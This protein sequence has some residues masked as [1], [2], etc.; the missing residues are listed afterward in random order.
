MNF[1]RSL[2]SRTWRALQRALKWLAVSLAIGLLQVL[3]HLPYGLTARFGAALGALLYL[4]PSKRKNIIQKNLELCFPHWSIE[5]RKVVAARHFQHAIR[6][7]VERSVQWLAPAEKLEK[8]I[9]V[10]SEVDLTDPHLPPTIFLGFH[11]VG[12][13]AGALFLNY[14]LQRP[15]GSVF[16][17]MSNERIDNLAIKARSRFGATM[18]PRTDSARALLRMLHKRIPVMLGSDM[19]HGLGNS[20]FVPFFNVPA[21]TLISLPRLAKA[22]H[23]QVAPFIC[24]VLPRYQGYKLRIFAPWS[25]YPS[26]DPIADTRRMNAFIEEHI[27]PIPEQYYWIHRRFKTRPPGEA[28]LY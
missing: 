25:D 2:P 17:P 3:A 22:A 21:C 8:L 10:E 12:L 28:G 23:A 13:E 7:F 14:L 6:S 19:D 9:Q 15:C 27:A 5:R 16:Q 18:L 26:D 4:L 1:L 11:F 24:E 20:A